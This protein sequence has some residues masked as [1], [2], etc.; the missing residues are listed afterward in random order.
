[1]T[2]SELENTS[3]EQVASEFRGK[4]YDVSIRPSPDA[5]PPFLLAFQPDLV[6]TSPA[7]N[8]VVEFKSSADLT[9]DSL[10]KLAEAVQSQPGWR[11]ELVVV[12][13][14]AAHEVP[15]RG[16]LASDEQVSAMLREAET[17]VRE[18]RYEAAA[19]MAWAAAEA[20]LRRLAHTSGLDSERKSSGALLKQLYALGLIDPDQYDAF[21]RTLEFRNAFA[22]GFAATVAPENV[23]RVIRDVEDLKSPPLRQASPRFSQAAERRT[24]ADSVFTSFF[25]AIAR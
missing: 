1:V 12:N 3:I 14:P 23:D 24:Y 18:N 21:A 5:T 4:G 2:Q 17:F 11:L 20:T 9:S 8:V 6:A 19:L 22:H 25:G 15:A 16:E 10:M 13:P 7:D